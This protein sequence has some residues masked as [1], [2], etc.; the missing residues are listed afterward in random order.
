MQWKGEGLFLKKTNK[1]S[2]AGSER[3]LRRG[4]EN[5]SW[6][7]KFGLLTRKDVTMALHFGKSKRHA[8]IH[9]VIVTVDG[10]WCQ[11]LSQFCLHTAYRKII[12]SI[13]NVGWQSKLETLQKRCLTDKLGDGMERDGQEG[14]VK[15][16]QN[17]SHD[18]SMVASH[19]KPL[20]FSLLFIFTCMH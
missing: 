8:V 3:Q 5:V 15:E 20:H 12:F 14:W 6:K 10:R 1:F 18:I 7:V 11:A 19:W 16:N 9:I 13:S 4:L 2:W 17:M